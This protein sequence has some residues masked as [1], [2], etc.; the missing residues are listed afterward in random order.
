MS[1]HTETSSEEALILI[2]CACY[3]AG[4]DPGLHALRQDPAGPKLNRYGCDPRPLPD[5]QRIRPSP[6]RRRPPPYSTNRRDGSMSQT[7]PLND[8]TV[9][10]AWFA[11]FLENDSIEELA[12]YLTHCGIKMRDG[13]TADIAILTHYLHARRVRHRA[14]ST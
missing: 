8:E 13:M 1:E 5:A 7:E 9:L 14:G 3:E 2:T 4:A 11:D 10:L 6:L 12:R